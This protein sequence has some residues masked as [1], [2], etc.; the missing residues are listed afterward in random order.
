MGQ[1]MDVR[2]PI[3]QNFPTEFHTNWQWWPMANTRAVIFPEQMEAIITEMD[4][5]AY[6]RPMAQLFECSVGGGKVLFS[7]MGLHSLQQYPEARALQD[8]IYKYLA[9]AEFAPA[10]EWTIEQL[11]EL[12]G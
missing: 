12:L 2:H 11:K 4:S 5:Y 8:A 1:L 3:F 9:S 7:S 10:Q 6:L